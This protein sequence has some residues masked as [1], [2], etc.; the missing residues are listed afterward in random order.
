MTSHI[1]FY[2]D[3]GAMYFAWP[4]GNIHCA[5]YSNNRELLSRAA[6]AQYSFMLALR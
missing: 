3:V 1:R 4:N 5:K 6:E 2:Q